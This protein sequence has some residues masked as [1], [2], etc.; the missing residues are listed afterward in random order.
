MHIVCPHCT[1][2]YAINPANLG[3][4]GRNVRCARCKQI[5]LARPEDVIQ[6]EAQVAMAAA[7]PP[8]DDDLASDPGWGVADDEPETPV[9]ESPPIAAEMPPEEA[10]PFARAALAH[11]EEDLASHR[12]HKIGKKRK[13]RGL[14]GLIEPFRQEPKKAIKSLFTAPVACAALGSVALGLLIW[15]ADVV[16]LMPQTAAF[17]SLIGFDVN[18]RGLSFKDVK[19]TR[20]MVE[21]KP[22]LVIEGVI[23]GETRKTVDVP[24]LRFVVRDAKGT[25]IYAWNA[26]L[27]QGVLRPGERAWFRSRLASPPAEA[28]SLDVRF[29]NRR[30][31]GTGGA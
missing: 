2:S 15:R 29:F 27:E 12:P 30:D 5:W 20:E 4:A 19:I 24:R 1:T 11:H 23:V 17:Y 21:S 26:V 9:V 28:R 6:P 3:E 16:R 13:T 31:I 7:E 8:P 14:K 25:E 10:D 22:V 18:L